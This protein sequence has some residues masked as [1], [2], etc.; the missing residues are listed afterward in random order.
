[1]IFRFLLL[2]FLCFNST[3]QTYGASPETDSDASRLK[4]SL[5]H[6]PLKGSLLGWNGTGGGYR[7]DYHRNSP[8][9]TGEGVEV[10][11]GEPRWRPGGIWMEPAVNGIGRNRL[12]SSVAAPTSKGFSSISGK[13]RFENMEGGEADRT[14]LVEGRRK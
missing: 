8:A 3:S 9:W 11:I 10:A 12:P 1:M 13:V 14:L 5:V 7:L 6:F 2:C 4:E